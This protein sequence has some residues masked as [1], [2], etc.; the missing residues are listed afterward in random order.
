MGTGSPLPACRPGA[1][2]SASPQ[3][4]ASHLSWEKTAPVLAGHCLQGGWGPLWE[5]R[6]RGPTGRFPAHPQLSPGLPR[7]APSSCKG[8]FLPTQTLGT[9]QPLLTMEG[10]WAAGSAQRLASHPPTP[11]P[12]GRQ[13]MEP[14]APRGPGLGG[15]AV[16]CSSWASWRC[17]HTPPPVAHPQR[18]VPPSSCPAPPQAWECSGVCHG[19]PDRPP[20]PIQSQPAGA[21]R[22]GLAECL[23]GGLPLGG[24]LP[25]GLHPTCVT[26]QETGLFLKRLLLEPLSSR[27]RL[28]SVCVSVAAPTPGSAHGECWATPSG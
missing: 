19:P 2:S 17:R 22:A 12:P 26:H 25:W 21:R 6:L 9:H 1:A 15:T 13:H 20:K 5:A 16:G 8:A 4:S 11:E 24:Q 10:P 28:C 7:W 14:C 23:V 27:P 18:D 3:T